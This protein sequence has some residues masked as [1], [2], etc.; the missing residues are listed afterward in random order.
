[1]L[2]GYWTVKNAA[3]TVVKCKLFGTGVTWNN[4]RKLSVCMSV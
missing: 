4:W 3:T 1:M 2:V